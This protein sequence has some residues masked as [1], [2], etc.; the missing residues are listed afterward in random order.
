[1]TVASPPRQPET[2]DLDAL[3]REARSRQ[4]RRRVG[5]ACSSALLA[6][7]ALG[8]YWLAAGSGPKAKFARGPLAPAAAAACS[9]PVTPIVSAPTGLNHA[10]ALGRVLWLSTVF[11]GSKAPTQVW[12]EAW[13]STSVPRVVLRGW[14]CSDGRLLHFWFPP[15]GPSDYSA[16]AEAVASQAQRQAAR[17]AGRLESGGGSVKATLRPG[18]LSQGLLCGGATPCA[19]EGAFMF[20]SAGKW[21]VL[22]QNGGRVLGT[23]VFDLHG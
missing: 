22:A 19:L 17:A 1:M 6:A 20:S 14:R 13:R 4:R 12:I 11:Y 7:L 18:A 3:V 21:V 23:A 2:D 15:S 10:R 16:S 8:V 5:I 9:G